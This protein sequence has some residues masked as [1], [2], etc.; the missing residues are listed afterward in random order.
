MLEIARDFKPDEI[1][2]AGDFH[3]S[4]CISQYEKEPT[5]DFKTLDE[6][7]GSG[8]DALVKL[9]KLF[10]RSSFVYLQGNHE[11]RI[12]RYIIHSA[13]KLWGSI[14]I[15]KLLGVPKSWNYLPYGQKNFYRMGKLI[16]THGS[17]TGKY[18]TL[19]MI[20]RYGTS[21]IHGHTHH[22]QEFHVRNLKGEQFIGISPGWLGDFSSAD[23]IKDIA[24]WAHG[25]ALTV[26]KPNGD[27]FHQIIHIKNGEALFNGKIYR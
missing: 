9:Q 11:N 27:F 14:D 20:E 16:A 3:D 15:K 17:I 1:I 6:E 24:N 5:R 22:I 2:I 21:I 4:Y 8:R 26:H 13:P 7:L 23:Y 19:K 12:E 25:F 18:A 10:P